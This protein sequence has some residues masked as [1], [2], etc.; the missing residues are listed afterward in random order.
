MNRLKDA[1]RDLMD[2]TLMPAHTPEQKRLRLERI[3]AKGRAVEMA[4]RMALLDVMADE[5]G[6]VKN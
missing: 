6:V 4:A 3:E 1:L 5:M 2:A